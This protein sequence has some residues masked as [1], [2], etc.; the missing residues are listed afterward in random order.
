MVDKK[1]AS[2]KF[3]GVFIVLD[4]PHCITYVVTVS[5]K[6]PE[7]ECRHIADKI[8]LAASEWYKIP[9]DIRRKGHHDSLKWVNIYLKTAGF[10]D[11]LVEEAG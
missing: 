9:L 8:L 1:Q 3:G 4:N 11:V 5:K 10:K 6:T 2:K 7:S